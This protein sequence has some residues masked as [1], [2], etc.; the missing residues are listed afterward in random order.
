MKRYFNP[1]LVLI[2][3]ILFL[4]SGCST[5]CTHEWNEATCLEPKTCTK[6]GAAEGEALGH[7][8]SEA[9]CTEPKVCLLCGKT[10]GAARGH[11]V[12]LS[13]E[14]EATC[15]EQ[16][17]MTGICSVCGETV[18]EV[19]PPTGIHTVE[20]WLLV[21]QATCS[22]EGNETGACTVCGET[23][24]RSIEKLPHEDDE[25]WVVSQA[26]TAT[27]PGEKS[28][29]CKNC[30]IVLQT[31][32]FELSLAEKNAL[33]SA[34]SY[35]SFMA[36]SRSG[37]IDQLEFEGYSTETA[38]VAVDSLQVDWYEQAA[39]SAESYLSFMSFSRSGL[40]SQLEFE[41][42]TREQAEYGV[43]AVGY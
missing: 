12:E 28:T 27:A 16:G 7:T 29:H 17:S 6:C 22:E 3:A 24:T 8:W 11:S 18:S 36:F 26:A 23:L 31:E 5:T 4:L 35:L 30:G 42:F 15:T 25:A 21:S 2:P 14:Q 9:T 39:K 10:D 32:S 37:L 41:G 1:R 40:I 13:V 43:S 19:I 34:E 38:T 20:N 33:R